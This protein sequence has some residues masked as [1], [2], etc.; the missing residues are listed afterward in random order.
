MAEITRER[1]HQAVTVEVCNRVVLRVTPPDTDAGPTH[2]K[3]GDTWVIRHSPDEA[4]MV[5]RTVVRVLEDLGVIPALVPAERDLRRQVELALSKAGH[6][7]AEDAAF[8]FRLVRSLNSG[9]HLLV[10]CEPD[11]MWQ[12]M[13]GQAVR[14]SIARHIDDYAATLTEAGYGVATWGRDEQPEVLIVAANQESADRQAPDIR[15]YLGAHNPS[16]GA[17]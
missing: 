1:I 3:D 7:A 6:A 13:P 4:D 9:A 11:D 5:A 12:K 15:A 16:G 8:G 2:F 17:R 14:T 10:M